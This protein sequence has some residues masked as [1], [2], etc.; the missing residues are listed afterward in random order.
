MI[1]ISWPLMYYVD[2]CDLKYGPTIL[3]G[4]LLSYILL[5]SLIAW[6]INYMVKIPITIMRQKDG[7]LVPILWIVLPLLLI[8]LLLTAHNTLVTVAIIIICNLWFCLFYG[9]KKIMWISLIFY[10]FMPCLCRAYYDCLYI[11]GWY[12]L[13]SLIEGYTCS[14]FTAVAIGYF[15]LLVRSVVSNHKTRVV[16]SE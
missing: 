11:Q 1:A 4:N 13:P 9:K 10:N 8:I 5:I 15:E 16:T 6:A 14:L 7:V 3:S 2:Y 12:E